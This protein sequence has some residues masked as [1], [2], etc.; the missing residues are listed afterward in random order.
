MRLV[1]RLV[2]TLCRERIVGREAIEA[3]VAGHKL[4]ED[5]VTI[6]AS[7]NGLF[8]KPASRAGRSAS[9]STDA[10]S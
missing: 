4:A 1:L 7:A 5:S 9:S 2:C 6:C 8:L 3:H 10:P